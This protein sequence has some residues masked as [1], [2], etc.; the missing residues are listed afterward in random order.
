MFNHFDLVAFLYDRVIGLPDVE[1]LRHVLRLPADGLMLDAGGGTG[2][3]SSLLRP[4]VRNVI[5]SDLSRLMLKQA[6]KKGDVLPVRAHAE[7]LPFPDGIFAR[8]LVVDSLHHFCNQREALIDLLR[9]LQPGGRLVVE[10][11]NIDRFAVKVVACMEKLALMGSRFY[12]PEEIR[13]MI[14]IHGVTACVENADR[15]RVWIIVDK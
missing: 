5:V 8:V 3:V 4:F 9:V 6:Q 1:R 11:P 7:R 14:E 10:E 2:R 15:F 12:S 13:N